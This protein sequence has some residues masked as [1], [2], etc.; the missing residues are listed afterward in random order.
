MRSI[1]TM[2]V[3]TP[4]SVWIIKFNDIVISRAYVT[5]SPT[6]PASILSLFIAEWIANTAVLSVI[7]EPSNSIR[8]FNH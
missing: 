4:T 6:Q 3:S 2:L 8:M 1:D 5:A 7:S